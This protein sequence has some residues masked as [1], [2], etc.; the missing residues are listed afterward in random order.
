M[1]AGRAGTRDGWRGRQGTRADEVAGLNEEWLQEKG[2]RAC[3][4]DSPELDSQ[5]VRALETGHI[6]ITWA[7]YRDRTAQPAGFPDNPSEKGGGWEAGRNIWSTDSAYGA[8]G[9]PAWHGPLGNKSRG[10]HGDLTQDT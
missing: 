1:Q 8:A 9:I 2:C 3:R 5:C 4:M 10:A 7:G 6:R